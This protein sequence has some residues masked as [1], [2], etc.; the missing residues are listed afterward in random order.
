MK[1]RTVAVPA[2]ARIEGE[3]GLKVRIRDGQVVGAEL[4]VFEPPRFFEAF[5]R[6]RRFEEVP[7]IVARICGI[8]PV[9]HQLTAIRALER[10]CGVE[11]EPGVHLLRRLLYLGEW[12]ESHALHVY[13]LHAPDFVNAQDA[14]ALA[15]SHADLVSRALRLKKTGNDIIAAIGGREIHP[16]NLRVGGFYRLPDPARLAPLGDAL[17]WARDAAVETVRWTSTL[18]C[19]DFEQDYELV[20][21]RE[22]QGY[23][24]LDG[25]AVSSAGLELGITEFEERFEEEHAAHSNALRSSRHGQPYLVG[26]IARLGLNFDRLGAPARAAAEEA[27]LPAVCRNPFRSIVVR[28]VELVEACDAA[29]ALLNAYEPPQKPWRSVTPRAARSGAWSEAPR[30]LLYHRYT[31][32]AR[33]LVLDARIVPPTAQN[34]KM[35]ERDLADFVARHQQLPGDQLAWRCEQAIRNYDPCISCATHF[36]RLTIERS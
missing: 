23:P 3:A 25:R 1:T 27:A 19:P 16:I 20:S 7:D 17:R 29:L 36:L 30:G 32:D 12:I 21:L 33:G 2:L 5:L 22:V 35:M 18:P 10:A 24:L 9:A 28:A 6:G 8:C 14:I 34:Q 31:I 11:I 15:G 4:H 26:P 13:L